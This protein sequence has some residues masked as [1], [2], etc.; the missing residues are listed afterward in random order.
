[1][2][3]RSSLVRGQVAASRAAGISRET[4][5]KWIKAGLYTHARKMT[6]TI[7]LYDV[8]KLRKLVAEMG[9]VRD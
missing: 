3:S 2:P 9:L 1:M 5:R 8:T 6:P 7:V 4:L